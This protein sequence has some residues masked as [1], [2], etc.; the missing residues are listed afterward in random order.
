[1]GLT[2]HPGNEDVLLCLAQ[3]YAQTNRMDK[4]VEALAQLPVARRAQPHTVE[5]IA[6]LH[7]R[8]KSPEKAISTI[9]EAVKYWA[10]ETSADE[11]TLAEVLRISAGLSKRLKAMD[12]TAEVYQLHLEKVDGGD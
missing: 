2:E 1:M 3:L 6:A 9:R 4:A 8:Q 10:E 7:M 5:A 11:E 12:L